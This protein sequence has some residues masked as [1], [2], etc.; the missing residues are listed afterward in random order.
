MEHLTARVECANMTERLQQ[1]I[2]VGE[3][4][5]AGEVRIFLIRERTPRVMRGLRAEDDNRTR[6]WSGIVEIQQ[7][8]PLGDFRRSALVPQCCV[9]AEEFA[10]DLLESLLLEFVEIGEGEQMRFAQERAPR[11][12]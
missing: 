4:M 9:E 1:G 10:L 12:E 8:A 5:Q 7:Q 11:G 2:G 6:Q 3:T